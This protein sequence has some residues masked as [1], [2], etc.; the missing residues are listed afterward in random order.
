MRKK[1][2]PFFV[3]N[4]SEQLK[5]AKSVI[6]V[7]YTGLSVKLQQELKK[8]L[9]EAGAQ[10]SIVKNTLFRL[11]GKNAKVPDEA[12]QDS[13]LQ[14]PTAVVISEK[15]A[16]TPLQI[17]AKFAKE[18]EILNFKVGI[19]E[20]KFQD[21]PSLEKLATLPS[22]EVLFGQ[23]ISLLSS[24][25]FGFVRTLEGNLQK[26]VFILKEYSNQNTQEMKS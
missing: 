13:V 21:K 9:K 2:K 12:L 14:G 26:L 11:A 8:R 5:S 24:P 4:L 1:E 25:I 17:L 10:I 19:I 20:G 15:D 3:Q 18:K 16:L 23:T 6:L 7:D 22:K